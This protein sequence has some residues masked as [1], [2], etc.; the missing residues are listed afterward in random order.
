MSRFI[1]ILILALLPLQWSYAAVASYCKHETLPTGQGHLGHHE[2]ATEKSPQDAPEK[3]AS[4]SSDECPVCTV[5]AMKIAVDIPLAASLA[6]G[7]PAASDQIRIAIY[8][9]FPD[10]PFRPPQ[11]AR[12]AVPA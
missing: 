5:A 4:E 8:D 9:P 11:D 3:P 1:A 2:L 12:L 6:I 7:K 10:L